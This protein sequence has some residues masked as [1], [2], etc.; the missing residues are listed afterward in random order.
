MTR[1]LRAA[2]LACAAVVMAL[3]APPAQAAAHSQRKASPQ[4]TIKVKTVLGNRTW[5][6]AFTFGPKG[7]L[8]FA[9]RMTG[10]IKFRDAKGVYHQVFKVPNVVTNGEQGLLGIA[11]GPNWPTPAYLYAYATRNLNGTLRNQ[12]LRIKVTK[13]VGRSFTV[14]FSSPTVAG[15]YH[16]GGRIMFGPDGK[17]YAIVGDAHD[18]ANAQ[19]MSTSAGKLLR[20]NADGSAPG[21]NPLGGRIF[22]RGVRNSFGFTFDTESNRLWETENGPDCNDELNQFDNGANGGWGANENCDGTSPDDTNNSG[23]T[24][25]TAPLNW[26]TPTIAPTGAVFCP[27]AGCGLTGYEGD[28]FFGSFNQSDIRAVTLTPDRLGTST[29]NTVVTRPNG[30]LSM[31]RNPVGGHLY[32]STQNGVFELV[33]G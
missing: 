11:V 3:P 26:W 19:D 28:L 5:P 30:I 7:T 21:D 20:M 18:D 10:Q 17:L 27:V 13:G 4:A 6:A 2:A 16:D 1:I 31:E 12:I 9:N 8:Y 29:I 32:F 25:R 24:P 22:A 23:P 14:I 33:G 15:Q